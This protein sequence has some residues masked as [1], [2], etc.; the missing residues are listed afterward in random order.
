MSETIKCTIC[1]N[2]VPSEGLHLCKPPGGW[3]TSPGKPDTQGLGFSF[4]M[5]SKPNADQ[6]ASSLTKREMIAMELAKSWIRTEYDCVVI[7]SVEAADALLA[8]LDRKPE[9][10]P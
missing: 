7:R 6:P 5:E 10:K 4:R 8:E 9:A 1:G 2:V 3:N